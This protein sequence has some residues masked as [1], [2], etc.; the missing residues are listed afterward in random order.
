MFETG[1]HGSHVAGIAAGNGYLSHGRYRGLAPEAH[2]IGVK[3]LNE[4]GL[5]NSSQALAGIQ[6]IIDNRFKYNIRIAN[7]SIGTNDHSISVPLI[8][9]ISAAWDAGILMV[10]AAGNKDT[11]S[12]AIAAPSQSRKVITVGSYEDS[13][14]YAA[15]EPS[16]FPWFVRRSAYD[17]GAR[18]D[19]VAP[20]ADIVSCLSPNYIFDGKNRSRSKI[21]DGSY[22]A[23]TGTSMAT[24]MVSGAAALLLQKEPNLT[25]DQI[26]NRLRKSATIT[27]MGASAVHVLNVKAL[28][29]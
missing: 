27:T 12:G 14:A 16:L 20:G 9:A 23:M 18:T 4:K 29:S 13:R 7:L 11:N 24:P 28:L 10:V 5:G 25:P 22:I 26:K 17:Y 8:R 1:R 21:V 6:W 2:I 3:I 19:L 15:A